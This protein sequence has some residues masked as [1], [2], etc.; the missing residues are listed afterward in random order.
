L[1]R[2]G[3]VDYPR[4]ITEVNR[5]ICEQNHWKGW[6][7]QCDR[8]LGDLDEE[9]LDYAVAGGYR[10]YEADIRIGFA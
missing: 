1:R 4:R 8:L 10:L 2:Q 5:I 7:S 6:L 9:A 3:D